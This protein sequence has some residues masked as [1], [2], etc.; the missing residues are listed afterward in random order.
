MKLFLFLVK[1]NFLP[2][3]DGLKADSQGPHKV[4]TNM[5]VSS[6]VLNSGFNHVRPQI[7]KEILDLPLE[8]FYFTILSNK[9]LPFVWK[10]NRENAKENGKNE[11]NGSKLY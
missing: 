5:S 7:I 6:N 2:V 11:N 3:F 1:R 9:T 4:S 8:H 10:Y